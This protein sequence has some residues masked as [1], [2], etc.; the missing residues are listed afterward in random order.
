M[1]GAFV[2]GATTDLMLPKRASQK[3]QLDKPSLTHCFRDN[4]VVGA[5]KVFLILKNCFDF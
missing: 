4:A 2:E 3:R 5:V 1:Y